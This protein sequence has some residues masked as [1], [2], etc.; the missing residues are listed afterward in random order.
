MCFKERRSR[1]N[2]VLNFGWR[3]FWRTRF[4][5]PEY[6]KGCWIAWNGLSN[7]LRQSWRA[8]SSGSICGSTWPGLFSDVKRKSAE[9]IAYFHDQDRQA[10]Q[11][12]IGQVALGRRPADRGIGAAGRQGFGRARRRAR[13]RSL[14][15]QKAR[16]GIG[17]R[18]TAM[19]RASGK[20]RQLPSGR[21]S[22]LR[23]AKG[24]RLGGRAA[25][26][27]QGVGEGQ[28]AA[29]EVRRPRRDS[30]SDAA[31]P[32]PGDARRASE[33]GC[34]TP[35]LRETTK[36]GA[37]RHFAGICGLW[38][39]GICLP[40]PRT[41]WSAIWKPTAAEYGG[42]GPRPQ[43]PFTR[44]DRW[45]E[46]LPEK[47]WTTIDVRDGA[48]G[49]LVVQAVKTRVQAKTDR[50]RNGPEEIAGGSAGRAERWNDEARLLS[51]ERLCRNASGGVCPRGQGRAS[52]RGV[53]GAGQER[54][55][56]G[57]VSGSQ[58]DRLASPSNAFAVGGVV[59][60]AR[61]PAGEKNT[62]RL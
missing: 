29:E 2:G 27:E 15:F 47:A 31:C 16:Q 17:G 5:I 62:L 51:F 55:G 59:P 37:A 39:S 38:E 7:P 11:K 34:L 48:R 43:V 57:S 25:V 21:L 18:R 1:W 36:W 6:R 52:D 45:R 9:T 61:R 50:R 46:A 23:F 49:P 28:A 26:S 40:C 24:A 10:L 3:S 14:G 4:W 33:Q 41:P 42:R 32:G 60:D 54:C 53:P 30:F 58:L 20:D 19:V 13:F 56:I 8:P 22:G 12:F 44:V 35:G